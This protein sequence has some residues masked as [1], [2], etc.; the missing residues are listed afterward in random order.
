MAH[1]LLR[2]CRGKENYECMVKYNR[3]QGRPLR[4]CVF[5][6]RCRKWILYWL[7]IETCAYSGCTRDD[8]DRHGGRCRQ[9]MI[10]FYRE[11]DDWRRASPPIVLIVVQLATGHLA[12]DNN[13]NLDKESYSSMLFNHPRSAS[14]YIYLVSLRLNHHHLRHPHPCP[15]SQI[16]LCARSSRLTRLQLNS[17]LSPRCDPA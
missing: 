12:E 3:H 5:D 8:A 15:I 1:W 11:V 17:F 4:K 6:R 2:P 7:W 14:V 13:L 9:I 16:F 10:L